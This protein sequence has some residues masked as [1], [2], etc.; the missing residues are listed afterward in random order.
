MKPEY[1]AKFYPVNKDHI[2]EKLQEIG[3]KLIQK[4]RV[5]YR[6]I[7]AKDNNKKMQVDYV[8]VRDE[9]N[10]VRLSA[11][12]HAEEGD[13]LSDQKELDIT[14]SSYKECIEILKLAGLFVSREQETKR[15]IWEF[16]GS[17]ITIDTWPSLETYIEI[18]SPTEEEIKI[19]ADKLGVHWEGRR[20]TSVVSIYAEV[21]NVSKEEAHERFAYATFDNPPF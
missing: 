15:E 9:G 7:F 17:E 4:E 20:I 5:M 18:E 8:R 1:E 11:K 12:I 3:A 2:R 16:E 14:V 21:Y 6:T 10:C 19:V 13:T